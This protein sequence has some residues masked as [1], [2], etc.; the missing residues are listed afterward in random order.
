ME[1]EEENIIL[2]FLKVREFLDK[3]EEFY[4]KYVSKGQYDVFYN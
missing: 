1:N 2:D 3:E 4:K